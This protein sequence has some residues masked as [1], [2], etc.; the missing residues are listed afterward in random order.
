MSD[1]TNPERLG[2]PLRNK[3]KRTAL[4]LVIVISIGIHVV[5]LLAF[6]VIKIVQT[7][8]KTPPVVE[9]QIEPPIEQPPPPLRPPTQRTTQRSM[10]RPQPMAVQNPLNLNMPAIEINSANM[11]M[12]LTGRG[13][14]GGL[15][16]I[17]G[18][19]MDSLRITSFG[20]DRMLEGT[21]KGELYDFKQ[22]KR[23][24]PNGQTVKGVQS[25]IRSFTNSS[26][27]TSTFDRDYFKA[28]TTLYAS[29]FIIPVRDARAAP[30]AFNAA[31]QIKPS[32][33]GA[34]YKGTYKPTKSGR[35][36]FYGRGDDVL[37]V[38]LNHRIVL[39][40]S[41][42][43]HTYSSWFP[44]N[45]EEST[46]QE[47]FG[48]ERGI[49]GI[50]GDWFDLREGNEVDIEIIISEVPGGKFGTWLTIEEKDSGTGPKIFS[51]RPLSAQDKDYLMKLHP[52]SRKFL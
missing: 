33:I 12:G 29:Y 47:Q 7:V 45:E 43:L 3:K 40:A 4:F 13:T 11:A 22:D 42:K 32:M 6:G 17:G 44:R 25:L 30:E 35:F 23:G 18:G 28:D 2:H 41:W 10:P 16:D 1:T 39:D 8:T 48:F 38:R 37:V 20:F 14:G 27:S 36:R 21:L 52:D 49:L 31:D 24:K 19:M 34:V 50:Y 46:G 51:T 5:G 9:S 15:G 26:W